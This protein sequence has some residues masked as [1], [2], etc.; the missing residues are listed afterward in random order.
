[1]KV[2]RA[3]VAGSVG[4]LVMTALMWMGRTMMGIQSNMEMMFGTMFGMMPGNAAWLLGFAIHLI[5]SGLIGLIYAWVIEHVTHRGGW[6]IG[7]GIGFVHA[8]IAG[9]VMGIMPEMHALIPEEMRAP[10]FF[11]SNMGAMTVVSE[12]VMHAIYG[13]VVGAMYASVSATRAAPPATA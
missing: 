9:L 10:G 13:G 6:V 4:G 3:F 5:G 12:F 7:A 11:M 8:I 1:M 2:G